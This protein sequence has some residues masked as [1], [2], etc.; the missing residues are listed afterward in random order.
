MAIVEVTLRLV[1]VFQRLI[2]LL[3][4][5]KNIPI[6]API[7]QREIVYRLPV[8]DQGA[9]LGQMASARSQSH[10]IARAIEPKHGF[11]PSTCA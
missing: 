3:T 2:D 11:R 5:P 7:I 1:A 9:H 10:K 8:G 6:P 4:E